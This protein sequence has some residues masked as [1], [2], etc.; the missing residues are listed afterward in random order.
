VLEH[1]WQLPPRERDLITHRLDGRT[2]AEWAHAQTPPVSVPRAFQL[3]TRA[4][5]RL[6]SLLLT[7]PPLAPR[8]NEAASAA[9]VQVKVD[10]DAVLARQ[11]G[12]GLFLAP[13]LTP[14]SRRP[15]PERTFRNTGYPSDR[16]LHP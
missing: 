11:R 5:K 12:R 16:G 3:Q 1:A 4:M 2:L 7:E 15:T 13:R 8:P 6:Q 9:I 10:I 14:T